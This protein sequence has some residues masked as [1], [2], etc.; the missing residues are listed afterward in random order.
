MRVLPAQTDTAAGCFHHLQFSAELV[1][2]TRKALWNKRCLQPICHYW[3]EC[4]GI[5]SL[6]L[7]LITKEATTVSNSAERGMSCFHELD[8]GNEVQ[9]TWGWADGLGIWLIYQMQGPKLVSSIYASAFKVLIFIAESM[10]Q[11]HYDCTD[12]HMNSFILET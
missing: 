9:P 8:S 5:L 7:K 11:P 2:K 4:F 6:S 3:Q 1:R 10:Q 12:C